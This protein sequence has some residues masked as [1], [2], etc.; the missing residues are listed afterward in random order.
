MN[1]CVDSTLAVDAKER[2]RQ[3]LGAVAVLGDEALLESNKEDSRE[4]HGMLHINHVSCFPLE[5]L[6]TALHGCVVFVSYVTR[7]GVHSY[8]PLRTESMRPSADATFDCS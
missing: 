3:L 2:L 5:V 6:C 8:D 7:M 1:A 4:N